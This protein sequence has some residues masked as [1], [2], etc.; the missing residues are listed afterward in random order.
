MN[1]LAMPGVT[2]V[3]PNWNRRD[4]V[5]RLIGQ[6]RAQS[7]PVAEIIV[8]DNGSNDGSAEAARQAGARVL[9]MGRNAG[10]SAAVNRGIAETKT[11]LMAVVNNDIEPAADWL[12]RLVEAVQEPPVW[13]AAGKLLSA[14]QPGVLDGAYDA[15]SRGA[16]AWRAGHGRKDGEVWNRPAPIRFAPFTATLFRTDLFARIGPLDEHFE[17]YLEDV[18]FCLRAAR[19]GCFGMY[20]PAAVAVHQGSAT[21][22]R[23]HPEVVERIARNQVLLVAKHYPARDLLRYGWPILVAQTLWGGVALRHGRLLSF[24]RGKIGGLAMFRSVRRE[25]AG[26]SPGAASLSEILEQSEAEILRL[27]RSTGFDLYWR[28]YF[29]LTSGTL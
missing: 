3:I 14:A 16:C 27:Q 4:L 9:E 25:A 11:D 17:S 19:Q 13:F 23:W 5:R 15:L 10:F 12:E 21:L 28:L 7:H 24:L 2:V 22:G 26:A 18:D 8:V 6:L 29:A 20:V 1:G